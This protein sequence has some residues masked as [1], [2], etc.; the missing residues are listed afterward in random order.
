MFSLEVDAV[1]C[2]VLGASHPRLMLFPHCKNGDQ[3]TKIET[4][5]RGHRACGCRATPPCL[6]L[7][8]SFPET[9]RWPRLA[10]ANLSDLKDHRVA[11]A[12]LDD[13][14]HGLH[15]LCETFHDLLRIKCDLVENRAHGQVWGPQGKTLHRVHASH[16]LS[17]GST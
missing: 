15:V 13:G 6:P 1:V 16:P 10:V 14:N 7:C 3:R 9:C 12:G 11:T 5:P 17:R 2:L 8:G 4:L